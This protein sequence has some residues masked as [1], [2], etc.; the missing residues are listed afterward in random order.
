ML[1][2]SLQNPH[3]KVRIGASPLRDSL[4]SVD[5]RF[6][7]V[8]DITHEREMDRLKNE[9]V[10]VISHELRTPLTSILGYTELLLA[11]DFS[12]SEQKQFL[13]T[14]YEQ[15]N[16]LS[17]L[18]D[19][20]LDSSRLETG[21]I[22]LNR[23]VI[24]L[25]QVISELTSQLANLERHRLLIRMH[26]QIPPVLIDRDK[27]KQVLF[28]LLTNAMK[29]SPGG[30]EIE[31]SVHEPLRLPPEHPPGRWLIVAVRDQG[32][33]I[34]AEDVPSIWERFY[35]VDNSNTR[36]IGGT[37]LGLSIARGLVE[38]HGGRIW[39]ESVL[40]EGSTF[41]FTLPVAS[42]IGQGDE[43]PQTMGWPSIR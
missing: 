27:I 31:L 32:I 15:A 22:K 25:R 24:S 29:Y 2:I 20:M 43:S 26:D 39:V 30:G 1:S 23:W 36:P 42:R 28:N 33:G 8:H 18:V 9:F 40:D 34:A 12:P 7:V 4:G 5:G 14:T 11:R 21:N 35:R 13:Q 19:D 10:S 16:H 37:G 3:Q 38:L 6:W 17:K 41:S